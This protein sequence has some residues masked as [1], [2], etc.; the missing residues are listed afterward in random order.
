MA[1]VA[2]TSCTP[3]KVDGK[4]DIIMTEAPPRENAPT[5]ETI[6]TTPDTIWLDESRL[7]KVRLGKP[8][9]VP[10]P[11]NTIWAGVPKKWRPP[12]PLMA[13]PGVGPYVLPESILAATRPVSAG[14]PK[15]IPARDMTFKTRNPA[16]FTTFGK[17]HG[18]RNGIVSALA[19]DDNGNFWM[20]TIDGV[21]KYDGR[22]F[23]TYTTDEGLPHNDVR[24]LFK[25]SRGD[26]WFGTQGGGAARFDGRQF[27][28]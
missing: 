11:G 21:T 20:G 17:Q 28:H 7:K 27:Y 4:A 19:E 2:Y 5:G 1:M 16:C 24:D 15:L 10:A 9:V 6:I 25:D 23:S 14:K 18:L 13:K 8:V 12:A 22:S 26:I 3:D